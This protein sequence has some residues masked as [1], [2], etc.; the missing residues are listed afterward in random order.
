MEKKLS[1]QTNRNETN[2]NLTNK[3]KTKWKESEITDQFSK[4]DFFLWTPYTVINWL[5]LE[6]T[7]KLQ[8]IWDTGP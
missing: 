7:E 1:Q 5:E 6:R 8:K 3:Q 4:A 2:S